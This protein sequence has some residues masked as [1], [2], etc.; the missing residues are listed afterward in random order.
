M[1]LFLMKS[2]YLYP[3]VWV[4]VYISVCVCVGRSMFS[5]WVSQKKVVLY[6]IQGISYGESHCDRQ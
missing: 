3:V 6:T 4:G 1:L 2:R 5:R